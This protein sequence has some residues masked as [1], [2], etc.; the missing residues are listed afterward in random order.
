MENDVFPTLEFHAH[1]F[2]ESVTPCPSIARIDVHVFAPQTL[3]AVI[4]VA[5]SAHKESAPF[6]GEV[7]LSTLEFSSYHHSF[8]LRFELSKISVPCGVQPENASVITLHQK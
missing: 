2:H 8:Y 1:G 7:F 5:T 6:A 4:R 3:R